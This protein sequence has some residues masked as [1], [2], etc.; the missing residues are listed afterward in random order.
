MKSENEKPRNRK[1]TSLEILS[2]IL[3]FCAEPKSLT[4]AMYKTNLSH[5]ALKAYMASLCRL[6]LVSQ[7]SQKYVTTEKGRQFVLSL[8]NLEMPKNSDSTPYTEKKD[9]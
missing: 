9:I 4:Q 1:R 8:E 5:K 7:N 3:E 6:G 2:D